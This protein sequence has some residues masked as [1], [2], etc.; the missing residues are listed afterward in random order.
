MG[1]VPSH[2]H[3]M[4]ADSPPVL[5]GCW[6]GNGNFLPRRHLHRAV[7]SMAPGDP[8]GRRSG[9]GPGVCLRA[10]RVSLRAGRVS[11]CRPWGIPQGSWRPLGQAAAA[12]CRP[13]FLSSSLND[14]RH[15][16]F[17]RSNQQC[18]P[19]FGGGD[20]AQTCTLGVRDRWGPTW[21]L[22]ATR[23]VF[24]TESLAYLT[25]ATHGLDEEAESL[26]ETF[27]PEKETVSFYLHECL[28]TE[29]TLRSGDS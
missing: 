2:A 20:C 23:S 14:F 22:S 15:V 9:A 29:L 26:K 7:Y 12:R 28:I 11:R 3:R 21:R 10:G 17:I 5:V 8:Q 1:R 13:R 4:A 27:D 25:A 6:L 16:L 18:I 19:H 24:F